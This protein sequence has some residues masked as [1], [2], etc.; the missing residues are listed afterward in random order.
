[1]NRLFRNFCICILAVMLLILLV[2]FFDR[3]E[4]EPP[5]L[6]VSGLLDGSFFR[7][8]QVSFAENFPTRELMR[9]GYEKL[10]GFYN[11]GEATEPTE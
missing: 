10:E 5:K 8:A 4:T 9:G 1:M 6:T 7:E 3:N 11:Y 2:S